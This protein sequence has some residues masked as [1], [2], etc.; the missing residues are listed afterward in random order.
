MTKVICE[1]GL[2]GIE[3]WRSQASA[4]VIV[5]ILSFSTAVSVAVD[6][7]AS[8]I[9]FVHGDPEAAASEAAR[10]GAIAASPKRALGGQYSLPPQACAT[11]NQDRSSC[12]RH[13]MDRA[14]RS[15]LAP[16]RP[17]AAHSEISVP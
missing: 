1:W 2:A 8:I 14:C 16:L 3:T 15:R 11:W 17:F 5:D 10:R 7:G 13:P 6:R 12:F 4:F 9:P